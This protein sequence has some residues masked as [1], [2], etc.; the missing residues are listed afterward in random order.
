MQE[1]DIQT[2]IFVPTCP[3]SAQVRGAENHVHTVSFSISSCFLL[4]DKQKDSSSSSHSPNSLVIEKIMFFA[5]ENTQA[6]AQV[7][8]GILKLEWRVNGFFYS[9]C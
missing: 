1:I 9:I 6:T 3:S 4:S 7:Q 5:A 2:L 8:K